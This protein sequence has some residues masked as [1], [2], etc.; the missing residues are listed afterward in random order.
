MPIPY[1]IPSMTPEQ[2]VS[3]A[4]QCLAVI[5]QRLSE[6]TDPKHRKD[7]ADAKAHYIVVKEDG[8]KRHT[9]ASRDYY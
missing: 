6:V 1:I 5:E 2:Q 4:E 3:Y 9:Y 8:K 7:L